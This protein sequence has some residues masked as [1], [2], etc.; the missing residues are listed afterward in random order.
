MKMK[1]YNKGG[2]GYADREDESLGIA[3]WGGK[4]K[5]PKHER[6]S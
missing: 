2:Q 6:S 3:Y 4:N 1:K 5:K